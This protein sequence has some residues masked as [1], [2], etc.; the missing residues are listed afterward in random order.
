[1]AEKPHTPSRRAMLAGLAVAPVAGLPAIA[2]TV[3]SDDPIFAAIAEQR[4]CKAGADE[5]LAV[6]NRIIDEVSEK[7]GIDEAEDAFG[8]SNKAY[9]DA[10]LGVLAAWPTAAA[11]ALA[12]LAFLVEHFEGPHCDPGEH[13]PEPLVGAVRNAL[14]VLQREA[15]S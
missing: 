11:A 10:E 9:F 8:E 6:C 12:L 4:C 5:A 7:V 1:M 2:V 13:Y 15:R 3:A 14:A